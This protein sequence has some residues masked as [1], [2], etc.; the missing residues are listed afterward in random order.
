MK[1]NNRLILKKYFKDANTQR[2]SLA[3]MQQARFSPD[4]DEQ[5]TYNGQ[6]T[7][8]ENGHAV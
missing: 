6:V 2:A 7:V 1:N 3:S 4:D 5:S 8:G